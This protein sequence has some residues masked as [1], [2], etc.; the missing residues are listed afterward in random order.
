MRA[1][2]IT[3]SVQFTGLL[4]YT[5]INTFSTHVYVTLLG[6]LAFILTTCTELLYYQ[7]NFSN[8]YEQNPTNSR[9]FS[10]LPAIECCM[11]KIL[12]FYSVLASADTQ[13]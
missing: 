7:L 3:L 1:I 12:I 9:P 6:V 8:F 2:K 10:Y 5:I 11:K 4:A 13:Y